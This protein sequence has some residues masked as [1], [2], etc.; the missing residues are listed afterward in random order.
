MEGN[1]GGGGV[2]I[3]ILVVLVLAAGFMFILVKSRGKTFTY[4][5]AMRYFKDCQKRN[6]AIVKG[7]IIKQRDGGKFRIIQSCLDK[8]GKVI[9]GSQLTVAKLDNELTA[10]FEKNN[11]VMVE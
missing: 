2:G 11:V 5:E 10:L 9:D 3:V 8:D 7:S 1:S 4:T 6:P